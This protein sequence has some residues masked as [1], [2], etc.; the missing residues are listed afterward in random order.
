MNNIKIQAVINVDGIPSFY[1]YDNEIEK[2][3][4]KH[5]KD[6]MPGKDVTCSVNCPPLTHDQLVIPICRSSEN[7][8][9]PCELVQKYNDIVSQ[10]AD[11]PLTWDN[12]PESL[13][14]HFKRNGM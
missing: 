10:F 6:A 3:L 13:K 11:S 2:I 14:D 7:N 5:F 9:P 12:P 4:T 1:F 8:M